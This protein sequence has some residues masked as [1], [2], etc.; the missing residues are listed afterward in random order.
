MIV[1]LDA[2]G[3]LILVQF[4]TGIMILFAYVR[5]IRSPI[6]SPA[7]ITKSAPEEGSETVLHEELEGFAID[8]HVL[9]SVIPS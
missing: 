4:S 6:G 7:L 3:L 9:I 1:Q 2:E 5:A 8:V